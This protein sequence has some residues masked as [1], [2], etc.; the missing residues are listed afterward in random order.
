MQR[1]P[2]TFDTRH[3][4]KEFTSS[5]KSLAPEDTFRKIYAT[6]HWLGNSISGQGSD[7]DQT[8]E[9]LK[10][11]PLL[12]AEY[13]IKSVLD[14]PCGDFNWFSGMEL[15]ISYIGGDIVQELVDNNNRLYSTDHRYFRKINLLSDPLAD[16]DL[17][18][19]RD[20]MVHLS[21]NDVLTAIENIRRSRIKYLLTTTFTE[22]DENQDII[23]GDWRIINLTLPPFNLPQPIVLINENCTEADGSY[24]DKCLGL[25]EIKEI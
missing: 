18:L 15:N 12:I 13:K 22:C 1:K 8:R 16:T 14:L 5:G 2:L 3:F 11:I 17:L 20:C 25:W 9:L 24:R 7:T 10:A 23:T 4:Q 21:N 19:C 6:N